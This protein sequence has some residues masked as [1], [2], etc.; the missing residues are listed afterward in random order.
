MCI[1]F[2]VHHTVPD[3]PLVMAANRDEFFERPT[4]P[5]HFWEDYPT[6][7][8]GKDMQAGGTWLGVTRTGRI[9]VVTNYR[10]TNTPKDGAP[11]RGKLITDF[12]LDQKVDVDTFRQRL[13]NEGKQYNGFNILFGNVNELF[14]YSN[15]VGHS[16]RLKPGVYGL[17]NHLLDTPWPKVTLGKGLLHEL[18][19]D[20]K[21]WTNDVLFG[22]LTNDHIPPD[23]LLPETGIDTAFERTLGS[24]FVSSPDY[25]TRCSTVIKLNRMGEVQAEERTWMDGFNQYESKGFRFFL[26][27]DVELEPVS[28]EESAGRN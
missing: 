10:E 4:L 5:M 9:A 13:D 17:S 20:P 18:P 22:L 6:L 12:L 21:Q 24:I 15:M 1:V 25:G 27:S 11:S 14:Y 8:A 28:L 16:T 7:L 26:D 2:L 3:L 19:P 23:H